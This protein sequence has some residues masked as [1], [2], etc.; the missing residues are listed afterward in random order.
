MI[1]TPSPHLLNKSQ[2]FLYRSSR[3]S[4]S[5]KKCVLRNFTKFTGKHLCQS[6]FFNKVA[7]LR[8]FSFLQ[9]CFWFF[10]FYRTPLD[11]CF[12]LYL[13]LNEYPFLIDLFWL[14]SSLFTLFRWFSNSLSPSRHF[15]FISFTCVTYLNKPK[16]F[17]MFKIPVE[18]FGKIAKVFL[19]QTHFWDN[20]PK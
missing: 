1:Y 4:C 16:E 14:I 8:L 13:N 9:D 11:H 18:P 5:M 2:P 17:K 19:P 15:R 12:L 6:L 20:E 10:L 7:G 3:Q